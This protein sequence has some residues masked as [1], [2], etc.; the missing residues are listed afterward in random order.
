MRIRKATWYPGAIPSTYVYV[1]IHRYIYIYIY[2]YDI[3]IH[4]HVMYMFNQ[5]QSCHFSQPQALRAAFSLQSE[6]G[7]ILSVRCL[8]IVLQD[9]IG[10]PKLLNPKP[11]TQALNPKPQT[12]NPSPKPTSQDQ[13]AQMLT[14]VHSSDERFACQCLE[15]QATAF[16][17]QGWCPRLDVR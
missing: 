3:R 5:L 9:A 8:N 12:L 7:S 13:T 2:L 16:T 11:S 17:P 14:S 1:Y 4:S 6:H 15:S 10:V